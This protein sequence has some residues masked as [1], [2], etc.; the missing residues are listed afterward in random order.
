MSYTPLESLFTSYDFGHEMFSREKR[1]FAIL[2]VNGALES[3]LRSN[4][5]FFPQ[6]KLVMIT[7]KLKVVNQET[8]ESSQRRF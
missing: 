4:E 2:I 1:V 7:N 6:L 5:I 8:P 3:G